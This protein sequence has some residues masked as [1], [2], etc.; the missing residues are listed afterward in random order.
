MKIKDLENKSDYIRKLICEMCLYAES[1]HPN[2]S[3]SC[4]DLLT[5]IFF[6]EYDKK[7]DSFI[8]SKG[9]A[10]PALYSVFIANGLLNKELVYELRN[11]DS[12]LQGHPDRLRLPQVGASTGALGQGLS[13]AIGRAIGKIKKNYSG[14][15]YCIIGDGETQEGQIWEAALFAG[16]RNV[17]NLIA[18]CDYNKGQSDGPLSEIMPLGDLKAKWETFGWNVLEINGH[19]IK[20]INDA[21]IFSKTKEDKKPSMIISHTQKGYISKSLTILDQDHGGKMTSETFKIVLNEL[22]LS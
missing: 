1:G 7:L 3:L 9:H 15:S 12:P 14:Y 4:A 17:H 19:S 8:L 13:M 10:A 5:V 2:S 16:N 20:E 22:D 21:V 6:S 18:F 11:F